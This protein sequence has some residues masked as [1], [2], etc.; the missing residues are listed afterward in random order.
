MRNVADAA[1]AEL[2]GA[3]VAG[4]VVVDLVGT[5]VA[6]GIVGVPAPGDSSCTVGRKTSD[7][8]FVFWFLAASVVWDQVLLSFPD[9]SVF[10][11]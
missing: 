10:A 8:G 5:D 4:A 3:D 1:V 7:P 2:A 9:I 11:G 6:D